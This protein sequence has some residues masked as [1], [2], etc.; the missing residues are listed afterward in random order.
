MKRAT[1]QSCGRTSEGEFYIFTCWNVGYNGYASCGCHSVY[2][3]DLQANIV[4]LREMGYEVSK[5]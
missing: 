4:A 1:Y 2:E 5:L 3:K